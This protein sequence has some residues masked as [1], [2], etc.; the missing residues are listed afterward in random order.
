MILFTWFNM[1]NPFTYLDTFSVNI[2]CILSNEYWDTPEI[3]E[4]MITFGEVHNHIYYIN[5]KILD[6]TMCQEPVCQGWIRN[7]LFC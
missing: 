6:L 2:S 4:V 3:C 7:Y 5:I 1:G